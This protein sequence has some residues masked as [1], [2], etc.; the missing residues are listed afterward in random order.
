MYSPL[1]KLAH[2]SRSRNRGPSHVALAV[3]FLFFAFSANLFATPPID[4]DVCVYGATSGGVIA[5]IQAARTGKTVSLI[6]VG[7]HVGGMT[8]SGLGETDVGSF[9]NSYIQGMA[10]EF[11]TRV[12]QKYGADAKFSFEPHVA[13]AVFN[14][15]MQEAGV[16]LYTDEFLVSI[17]TRPDTSIATI[18]MKNSNVFRA[19]MFIDASYEG[20]LMARVG[21][22]YTIGRESSAQYG[23]NLNG[24]RPPNTGGH[25]F[26]SLKI[27]PYVIT[28]DPAS[29]L[30]PF[31]Q[32]ISA[33]T[34]GSADKRLQSYNFRL[35]LTQTATNRLPLTAPANYN[36]AQYELLARYIQA[37][38]SAG[39]SPKLATFM[40]IL[41][42]P[43][44]KTD[45]NNNGAVSTDFIGQNYNYVDA[46]QPTRVQIWQSHKNYLQGFLYFLAT[47]PRVPMN[48]RTQM[49]S[50]GYCRD[51]FADNGGWPYELYVREARRM[52]SDYV[53]TESNCLG[54]VTVPDS[55]GLAAYAMDSHNIERIVV[56]G[57]VENEGDTYV[58]GRVPGVWTI[59]YRAI[60]PK[61]GDCRNLLVPWCVSASH[62]AFGS[63]RM[64]PVFMI[65]SQS[66]AEAAC[67]A[68]D[69]HVTVQQLDYAKLH[70]KL[71]ASQQALQ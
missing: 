58:G 22:S 25:Q 50:Y 69:D 64:E 61:S 65:V 66:A 24:V 7:N 1:I 48:V 2:F 17:T 10:R 11:Y 8:S 37:L 29:G 40:N 36:P 39:S 30:I 16:K 21:V 35:C 57:V 5:A 55:I 56:N 43:N 71:I 47:D 4:S 3:V 44:G 28:S 15:M 62:I 12:G 54:Q 19:K 63:F 51:E 49:Q 32:T 53:M 23:E 52:I 60:I 26:G 67:L 70:A 33:D 38:E 14:E 9:G 18:T 59:P 13:E 34:A 41:R 45:I 20:D 31:V 46:D 27:N 68:I 42:M 6:A